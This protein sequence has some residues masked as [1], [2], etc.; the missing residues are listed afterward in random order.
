MKAA[1][2]M[3]QRSV[4]PIL[5]G[6]LGAIAAQGFKTLICNRPDGE[7]A[8]Q[9]THREL[10]HAAAALGMTLHYLP[11]VAGKVDDARQADY[12]LSALA[13][14]L[15]VATASAIGSGRPPG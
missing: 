13:P 9:P 10:A 15:M 8:D 6:D 12:D 14:H 7:G 11:V 4:S 5:P 2:L 1:Q 3:P